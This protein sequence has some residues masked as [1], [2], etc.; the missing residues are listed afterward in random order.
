[1][2][3]GFVGDCEKLVNCQ[4][5]KGKGGDMDLAVHIFLPMAVGLMMLSLGLGL[6]IRDFTRVFL[7]PK[8]FLIGLSCQILLFPLVAFVIIQ[9][10]GMTGSIA[11]GI[12]LLA[13]CPGGSTSNLFTKFARGNVALSVSL[14]SISTLLSVVSVALVLKWSE[15]YFMGN[16]PIFVDVSTIAIRAL[17]L[18]ALPVM[19]GMLIRHFR[20]D[21]ALK[22]EQVLTKVAA[23]LLVIIIVGAVTA[24]WTRFIEN[25]W[26]L[27][28]ALTMLF[29][30][31]IVISLVVPLMFG[32]DMHHAK[33]ISIEVG[34]QNG[35]FGI[36]VATLLTHGTTGFNDYSLASA[37]YG[38]L[39]YFTIIPVIFWYRGRQ[40][41]LN[42]KPS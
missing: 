37:I 5:V 11:V 22:A 26:L 20:E 4:W 18:T 28:G 23:V 25:L 40:I 8:A 31:V 9:A 33:T 39:V 36:T 38:V 10:F 42:P 24:N 41:T 17:L 16:E 30:C 15:Q 35:A 29:I 2:P 19:I 32:L 21:L 1:M 27:G 14:T 34:V 3:Y 13:S 6:T 12:M 7:W